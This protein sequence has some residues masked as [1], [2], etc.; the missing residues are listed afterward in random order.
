MATAAKPEETPEDTVVMEWET[1]RGDRAHI[2]RIT[3]E[4]WKGVGVDHETVTWDRTDPLSEGQAR[5]SARAAE[6]L[7]KVEP[8]FKKVADENLSFAMK[9]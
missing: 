1:H 9:K 8:G 5:V 3:Q 2:R 4:D 7:T 6:Y